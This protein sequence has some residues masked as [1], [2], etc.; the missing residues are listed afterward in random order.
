MID[1]KYRELMHREID[2]DLSSEE[3]HKLEEYLSSEP[4]AARYYRDLL[5]T[6]GMLE[7][8]S[9]IEPPPDSSD[10]ILAAVF[11]RREKTGDETRAA[12]TSLLGSLG[13]LFRKRHAYAF[14]AGLLI[15]IVLMAVILLEFAP[16]QDFL[17]NDDL[18]GTLGIE[19]GTQF[20]AVTEF[21]NF[22]IAGA[23]GSVRSGTMHGR[24]VTELKISSPSTIS[25]VFEYDDGEC[26]MIGVVSRDRANY[27]LDVTDTGTEL[28]H[29]GEATYFVTFSCDRPDLPSITMKIIDGGNVLLTRDLIED[30]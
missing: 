23:S 25:I 7:M 13:T 19:K 30:R 22:T 4:E 9:E 8:A 21:H 17:R 6:V 29:A 12:G 1:E 26:A 27:R 11:P 10:R 24:I 18:R 14:S 16:D 20:D 3:A 5:R 2:G 28:S 15:G